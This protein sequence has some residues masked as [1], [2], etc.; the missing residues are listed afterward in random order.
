MRQLPIADA[1]SR[2][3]LLVYA[4]SETGVGTACGRRDLGPCSGL[5]AKWHED[6]TS[7][8]GR[9]GNQQSC[10]TASLV[11]LEPQVP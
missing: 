1:Q 4:G 2:P 7:S 9:C 8:G 5:R 10:A 3:G 6:M 11:L